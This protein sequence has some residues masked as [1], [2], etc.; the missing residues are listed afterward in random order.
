MTKNIIEKIPIQLILHAHI[1]YVLNTKIDYWIY[2]VVLH[3]Y[4]PFLKILDQ[5]EQDSIKYNIILNLSPILLIQL[6]SQEFQE[7]FNQYL[8]VREEL[9]SIKLEDEYKNDLLQEDLKE[10]RLLI[11]QYRQL[12]DSDIIK[13][14]Q[15][16]Q[17]K[18]FLTIL[19][20]AITH[21]YL[22]LLKD[23][24]NL[25]KLQ[26]KLGKEI[27]NKYFKDIKGFWSPECGIYPQL[28]SI[29]SSC[30]L[31]YFY[32]DTSVLNSNEEEY[33]IH[34]FYKYLGT[35][36]YVRDLEMTMKIWDPYMGYP[37]HDLYREFHSDFKNEERISQDILQKYNQFNAGFS[38][39]AITDKTGFPKKLYNKQKAL[40]QIKN[41]AQDYAEFCIK[42]A[43]KLDQIINEPY[44]INVFFDMELFGHWWREGQEFLYCFCKEIAK[45][46]SIKLK[47][48]LEKNIYDLK[49]NLSSWGKNNNA[50]SWLNKDTQ[51]IWQLIIQDAIKIEDQL[52][53]Q[54]YNKEELAS[55]L[56]ALASDW[57][58]LITYNSFRDFSKRMI[59]DYLNIKNEIP[60][61]FL[62]HIYKYL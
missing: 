43:K 27:S 23:F 8:K 36:Y 37:S 56:L 57:T 35:Q 50:E 13:G 32:A 2:E 15:Y 34:N 9:L 39:L 62:V 60:K 58:F 30:D 61:N 24:P 1:P 41:D 53:K 16:F 11:Q 38:L 22:P 29:L 6:D 20:S 52:I 33:N 12:W 49:P 10:F 28:S 5:L 47:Q 4:L 44:I 21:A 55:F 46:K 26:I 19:T 3:S 14:F 25:V 54:E 48:I 7:G 59:L 31:E 51:E 42:K 18:G 40:S 45:S 17:R